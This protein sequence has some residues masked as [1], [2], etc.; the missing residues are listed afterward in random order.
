MVEWEKVGIGAAGI[1][2]ILAGF[3]LAY[4]TGQQNVFFAGIIILLMFN[5]YLVYDRTIAE[6]Y[7][8]PDMGPIARMI[9]VIV[10]N[11]GIAGLMLAAK[12][13]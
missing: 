3:A 9:C 6:E 7:G 11:L 10:L 2:A 13:G 8:I 1:A 5:I 4:K 12:D